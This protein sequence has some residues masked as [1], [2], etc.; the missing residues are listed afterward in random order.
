VS[1][2]ILLDGPIAAALAQHRDR[3]NAIV[4]NA[5]RNYV[6]FDT[7]IL[8]SQLRGPLRDLVDSCDRISPGS[9]ARVLAAIF[10]DVVELVG[11]HRLG[12]G[13]HDPLVSAL[14][15]LTRIVVDEPR[16]VF[17]SLAN[18]VVYLQSFG[19]PVGEWLRRLTL[20]AAWGDAAAVL[21]AGQVAAWLLGV[22]QFRGSALQVAATL[23]EAAFAAALGL[24]GASPDKDTL[25]RLRENRWWRPGY[26]SNGAPRVAHRVGGF[27]GFGGP[28]LSPPSVGVRAGYLVVRAGTDAWLLH[29]D[30]WGATLTR[31]E[32]D[33]VDFRSSE[34]ALV[35][36]G[37]RPLSAAGTN[38]V[39]ALTLPTS[40]QVLVV[41]PGR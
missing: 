30:A 13:S 15:G 28:F 41:E 24:D 11:Q 36:Q 23:N 7:G 4:A 9:G 40:Y 33:G 37:F 1:T 32:P 2:P 18:G 10:D 19:L 14:P 35:P 21:R 12:G 39:S 3:F 29:A 16:K 5:R 8:E 27:R 20:A 6:D 38:D 22:S 34:K 25:Q 31:T 26:A 17:G